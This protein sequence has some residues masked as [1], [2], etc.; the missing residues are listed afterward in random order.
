MS[1]TSLPAAPDLPIVD[2]KKSI[3]AKFSASMSQTSVGLRRF[4]KNIDIKSV[5]SRYI[6]SVKCP[7]VNMTDFFE[8]FSTP[9]FGYTVVTKIPCSFRWGYILMI[10]FKKVADSSVGLNILVVCHGSS[11]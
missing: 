6:D 3:Q 4:G 2:Q 5:I 9:R 1:S 10:P 11:R 7:W 8:S